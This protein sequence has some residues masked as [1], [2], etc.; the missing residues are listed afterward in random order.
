VILGDT[1]KRNSI[2]SKKFPVI[3]IIYLSK[4][5]HKFTTPTYFSRSVIYIHPCSSWVIRVMSFIKAIPDYII[6][7]QQSLQ[8]TAGQEG[9][10][11]AKA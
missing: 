5:N 10:A 9:R 3:N 2:N 1:A 6:N 7:S 4:Y 11:R 8:P